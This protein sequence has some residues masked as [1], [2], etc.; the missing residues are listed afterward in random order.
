MRLRTVLA[1]L[2]AVSLAVAVACGSED[3]EFI[4]GN[5]TKDDGGSG[6]PSSFGD[7]STSGDDAGTLPTG[8]GAACA[9]SKAEAVLSKRPVDIIF[10]VD[11]SGSMDGEIIE[12]QKQINQNF[13][14][15]IGASGID[16]RVIMLSRYGAVIPGESICIS[17]PLSG[18]NC[19]QI[20]PDG[21]L[22]SGGDAGKPVQTPT[23]FHYNREI[24]SEDAWCRL[25]D[26][27]VR[28]DNSDGYVLHP[29]GY[30]PLLRPEAFKTIVVMSDDGINCSVD[31]LRPDGGGTLSV[32]YNDNATV[33][34]G[35]SAANAFDQ[36]LRTLAPTQFGDGDGG[37]NYV[38]HSIVA[39][40][41]F[42]GDSG[43]S[44]PKMHPPTAPVVTATCTPGAQEPGTGHQAL[45]VLT[46]GFRYPSCTLSY[47]A[48]FQE[49]AKGVVKSSS[50]AC[51]F[52]VPQPPP[53]ETLDLASLAVQYTPGGDAGATQ[54]FS[55]VADLASC[56]PGKVWL[57]GGATGTVHLCPETCALVKSDLGASLSVVSGC[58][59]L[60]PTPGTPK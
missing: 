37:R 48:I 7:A 40:A 56:A 3:S 60:S 18:A 42:T 28:G 50:V 53:G 26:A 10:V 29:N 8:D 57:E 41:P 14:N 46:G 22:P 52:P 4:D 33:N 38:Y 45:S 25:L 31:A 30:G 16:F 47:T 32:S 44:D 58:A 59:R 15:I 24:D 20:F 13:A 1:G 35:V 39:L 17:G 12:V 34:G 5:G 49:M 2:G 11:N 51:D 21:S 55:L 36:H 43:T 27:F 19:D 6:N 9:S 54:E 23:F